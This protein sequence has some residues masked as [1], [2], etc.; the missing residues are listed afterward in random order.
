[1][2]TL[3]IAALA[4]ALAHGA[5]LG[6]QRQPASEV[7]GSELDQFT[8]EWNAI[9]LPTG[10]KPASRVTAPGGH[11]HVQSEV[12]M[13]MF[14]VKRAKQL[15]R[16]GKDHEALLHMDLVRAWLKLPEIAHPASHQYPPK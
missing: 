9:G 16:E 4:L 13:M 8:R 15:C 12:N 5:A 6:Q 2:K 3:T 10:S 1:M 14:H 7:C 11:S